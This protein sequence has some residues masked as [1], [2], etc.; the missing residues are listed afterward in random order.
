[1]KSNKIFIAVILV[2]AAVVFAG[3]KWF[4]DKETS[5]QKS[6]VTVVDQSLLIK[7]HSPIKGAANAKVTLVEFLDPECEACRA[8]HPIVKQLLSEYEGQLRVVVRYLPFHGN[9]MYAAAA[10]EEAREQGKF[11]EALDTLFLNQPAWGSH[12]HPQ[13]ELIVTYLSEIGVD[14][15][16]LE[17]DKV[18]A[19][20]GWKIDQDAA[21]GKVV[22]ANRTPTFFVNGKILDQIGYLPLKTAID[23][24]LA[25]K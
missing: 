1:M 16:S 12:A 22:G 13:P 8:M 4:S 24:E 14:K 9:S 20:H 5:A 3:V 11:D 17:K 19:K 10:I 15:K 21:D 2:F 25:V 6:E 23:A 7:D 18:I